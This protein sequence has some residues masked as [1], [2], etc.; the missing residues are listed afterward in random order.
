MSIPRPANVPPLHLDSWDR[1]SEFAV[2]TGRT[3][4]KQL[5]W[6]N[7]GLV[8]ATTSKTA[9]K[10]YLHE[11]LYKNEKRVYERLSENSVT[12][13]HGFSVPIFVAASDELRALEM[14]V[15]MPPF[16]I[17]FAGAYL[18]KRPPY[19]YDEEIM[20]SWEEAGREQ[21]GDERW[22]KA[23]SVM[24][25]FAGMRIYLNDVHNRNLI[26]DDE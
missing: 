11:N 7:E 22:S 15:V 26:F 6:G 25:V 24:A 4:V 12:S 8:Y 9:I 3:L 21:F 23:K 2:K 20:E 18:D 17:D 19:A 5:G 13:V 10:V 14:T 1:L 16:I